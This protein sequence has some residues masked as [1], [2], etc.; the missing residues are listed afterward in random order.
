[1]FLPLNSIKVI[2]LDISMSSIFSSP[3]L[4][5]GNARPSPSSSGG[6][7]RSLT[8]FICMA[9]DWITRRWMNWDGVKVDIS[10]T[11]GLDYR[12]MEWIEMKQRWSQN[13]KGRT[14]HQAA[15][16]PIMSWFKCLNY[17]NDWFLYIVFVA[18]APFCLCKSHVAIKL[19]LI[20][21]LTAIKW[22]ILN[23][24]QMRAKWNRG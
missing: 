13:G 18:L 10:R 22:N 7:L 12:E 14:R 24:M 23:C 1:M 5:S 21:Y 16:T 2:S 19:W 6:K 15:K 17:A 8:I 11:C 3:P 9:L 4:R 20:Y